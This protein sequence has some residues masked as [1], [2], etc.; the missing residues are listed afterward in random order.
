VRN[1]KRYNPRASDHRA[2]DITDLQLIL[3]EKWISV[4]SHP[5][6]YV[7]W[8]RPW[9]VTR[10]RPWSGVAKVPGFSPNMLQPRAVDAYV[11]VREGVPS[12]VY[13]TTPCQ[14]PACH[15]RPVVCV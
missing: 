9:V 12:M 5:V 6:E 11:G 1:R 7:H 15:V 14:Y 8:L 10:P 2:I 4:W 13:M 3:T